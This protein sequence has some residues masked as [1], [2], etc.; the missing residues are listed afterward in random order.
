MLSEQNNLIKMSTVIFK[1]AEQVNNCGIYAEVKLSC[2]SDHHINKV[3][4]NLADDTECWRVPILFGIKYFL[5]HSSKNVGLKIDV[6][7]VYSNEV[8]TN[9]L[10]VSYAI[11]KAIV[12]AVGIELINDVYF[13]RQSKSFVFP[14]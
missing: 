14:K 5:E 11:I 8:D 10:V 3:E 7:Y 1:I 2:I 6:H 9:S 13:E 12:K 4:L